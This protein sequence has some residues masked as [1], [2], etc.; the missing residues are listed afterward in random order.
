L[1]LL[2]AGGVVLIVQVELLKSAD[3]PCQSR[4]S[5]SFKAPFEPC[6]AAPQVRLDAAGIGISVVDPKQELLYASATGIRARCTAS[7]G[8]LTLELAIKVRGCLR[9]IAVMTVG[10]L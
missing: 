5:T 3:D 9:E 6:V 1:E 4:S 7:S 2:A 10:L 8:R